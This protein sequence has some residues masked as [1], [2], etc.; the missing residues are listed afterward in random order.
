MFVG[1]LAVGMA[2]KKLAPRTSLG[3]LLLAAQ[4]ADV[5]WPVLVLTGVEHV[6]VAPGITAVTPFDFY[7]YP[8]SHSLLMDVAW[9]GLFAGAYFA[10]RRY[11]RGAWVLFATVVSHWVLDWVSHRPDMP[12]AP[13]TSARYGLGLWS[14]IPLTLVVE[15]GMWIAGIAVY[16]GA[17]KAKD[18]AGT[19]GFWPMIVLLTAMWLGAI[20]GPAPPNGR[21]AAWSALS[22]VVIFAWGYWVDGHRVARQGFTTGRASSS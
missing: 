4:M 2:A 19:Q 9:A 14:S 5:V 3:T 8:F 16:L 17:T 21:A 6:R 22:M 11:G 12:L 1:H 7:D 13:G 15:G 18:W 10:V 20:F